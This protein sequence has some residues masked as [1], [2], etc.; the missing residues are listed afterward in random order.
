MSADSFLITLLQ[1]LTCLQMMQGHDIMGEEALDNAVYWATAADCKKVIGKIRAAI[2]A[3]RYMAFQGAPNVND[4]LV[5][6]INNVAAQFRHS[7]QIYNAN[8]P[9]DQTAIADF[10]SEWVR[11]MIP[12][13]LGETKTWTENAIKFARQHWGPRTDAHIQ[14]ALDDLASLEAE[15]AVAVNVDLS[16]VV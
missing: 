15:L 7:Q 11:D 5:T 8:Y 6:V 13:L 10:W 3:R 16:S 14:Q 4:R 9:N 2:A 1:R 12:Y